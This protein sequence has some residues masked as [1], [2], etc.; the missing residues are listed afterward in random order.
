MKK[1]LLV[2]LFILFN[3]L[4]FAKPIDTGKLK[5]ESGFIKNEGQ[6]YDQNGNPNKQV[7]FL[8]T[9]PS[10][11]VQLR[12]NGFSYE[13]RQTEA[14]T[15]SILSEPNFAAINSV[16]KAHR[17]DIDFVG[18]NNLI[19]KIVCEQNEAMMMI[20]SKQDANLVNKQRSIKRILY[21]NVYPQT[22]I[23]F[24]V[25]EIDGKAR[26]KY[27]IILHPGADESKLQFLIEGA[28]KN[29]LTD[30]GSIAMHTSLGVLE[31]QVPL[32]YE[33]TKQGKQGR[34]IGARFRQIHE[35]LFGLTVDAKNRQNSLVIDPLVW[36][37]Y[38]GSTAGEYFQDIC[39]DT[40][41]NIYVVGQTG[42]NTNIAT[43]GAHQTVLG[44]GS[45]GFIA[46][47]TAA[48]ILVWCTYY[49]GTSNDALN[50]LKVD[51]EQNIIVVG[52]S[53]STAGIATSGTHSSSI[54]GS[55]DGIL[56][57]FSPSGSIIWGTYFGG[58]LTENFW[59][60]NIDPFG[61]IIVAGNS[62]SEELTFSYP[63][64]HHSTN[65][66]ANDGLLVK[67]STAGL[68]KWASFYG[69]SKAEIIYGVTTD[70]I[71]NIYIS[72]STS[73]DTGIATPGS[74]KPSQ[75]VANT[76]DGFMAKFNTLG[77]LKYGTYYGDIGS[78]TFYDIEV[79]FESNI[80]LS[81]QT[82]SATGIATLGA[83][84][85]TLGSNG[86][87]DGFVLKMDT[88]GAVLW[89]TYYG[90]ES[91]DQI[92]RLGT[93]AIG[94]IYALGFTNS[95]SD[96]A[97]V[98]AFQPAIAGSIDGL[99][100]VFNKS[101]ARQMGTYFGGEST[102]Y[103]RAI[104]INKLGNLFLCGYTLS[105]TGIVTPN[106][107]DTS[108]AGSFDCFIVRYDMAAPSALGNN[109]ISSDQGLCLG[110]AAALL[111]GTAPTG[112]NNT[113]TYLWTSSTT[114]AAG[115]YT[116]AAGVN[117]TNSYS[118][119]VL[120]ANT[121]YKRT[122][123]S[124]TE[125]HTSNVVSIVVS[126][127]LNAGFTLNKMIQ[128]D[129]GNNFVFTDTT[130]AGNPNITR[131]WDFGNGMYSVNV[132]DSMSYTFGTENTF[133]VKL[134]NSI[135]G[136]CADTASIRIYI[137]PNPPL[138]N[139]VGNANV[140]RGKTETY[141]VTPRIGSTYTWMYDKGVGISNTDSIKIKWTDLGTTELKLLEQ[142]GGGCYGDTAYLNITIDKPLGGSE[143][144]WDNDL[145]LYPNPSHGMVYI[146]DGLNRNLAISVQS[147]LGEQVYEGKA[148][149]D[150][151][152]DLS[153]L[154][155]GIYLIKLSTAEGE[156]FVR[157]IELLH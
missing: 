154:G 134:I 147:I 35:R 9:S 10:L 73:S 11:S 77:I 151:S 8:F 130:Q 125:V 49:G 124:G 25:A 13:F 131:V 43:T 145:L 142:T 92:F 150:G 103:L 110:E 27:N 38:L 129:R 6:I 93:D 88:A 101:G 71:G 56:A 132:T 66:G 1:L 112:G 121:W 78:E 94:N 53:R 153:H 47:Y 7:L 155:S 82:N 156:S 37:T 152:I 139:I 143:M 41:G 144:A 89:S 75:S 12:D 137:I 68:V 31:E 105:A 19:E 95:T 74:Y 34:S 48:G 20:H 42:S 69:G 86:I 22:D 117:N 90:G 102:D 32:S 30:E 70:L 146:Q 61:D 51:A 107:Y 119:G 40:L 100:V 67:F 106:G 80:V 33:L 21:K 84:D 133:V 58:L 115:A 26:F 138:A 85:I 148:Q 97:S 135:N 29:N 39:L 57:K 18:S 76:S 5:N 99:M 140:L 111:T 128:C 65:A 36:S 63:N 4:V 15:N 98:G 45:D 126:D 28:S 14:S 23:E 54:G 64:T 55:E 96:I 87:Q 116:P 17:I 157:K 127:K 104:A 60:V 24:L 62:N 118:P 2:F 46:K 113:Y 52:Q 114:G 120:S 141:S 91:T 16:Q 81:G 3:C 123:F 79:D 59:S 44:G 83:Y 108:F 50:A 72:G 136:A 122:V 149:L 109:V